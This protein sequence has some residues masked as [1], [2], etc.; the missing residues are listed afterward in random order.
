MSK[1]EEIEEIRRLE[2]SLWQA[3]FRYDNQNMDNILAPDFVEFGRSGKIY[4]RSEMFFDS[5]TSG[6]IEAM[7]PLPGFKACHIGD[8][9]LLVTYVSE[10]VRDG[11][12]LRSNRSSIWRRSNDG[13]QLRFH[14]GT[15]VDGYIAVNAG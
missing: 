7:L 1:L 11:K 2:E 13:W 5:G 15:P 4:S 3:E 14:Q 6:N 10:L 9:V 8:G 12:T